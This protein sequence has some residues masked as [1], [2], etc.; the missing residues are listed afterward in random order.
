MKKN[1]RPV[2]L[3]VWLLSLPLLSVCLF[4]LIIFFTLLRWISGTECRNLIEG[5][6]SDALHAASSLEALHWG[7]FALSSRA[8]HAKG[9]AALRT[10]E[11][12][13]VRAHLNPRSIFRGQWLVEEISLGKLSLRLRS[14]PVASEP[15][16]K[17][18][19]PSTLPKWIP[20]LVIV[21]ALRSRNADFFLELSP[22]REIALLGT[23]L[24]VHPKGGEMDLEASKGSLKSPFLPTLDLKSLRATITGSGIAIPEGRFA[25]PR[26]GD[27]RIEGKFPSDQTSSSLSG[28]WENVPFGSLLTALQGKVVG[29][30]DGNATALWENGRCTSVVGSLTARSVM[31]VEVPSLVQFARLTGSDVFRRL[32]VDSFSMQ[33]DHRNEVTHW[34]NVVIESKGRMKVTGD[35]IIDTNKAISGKFRIGLSPAT[36]ELVP[37]IARGIFKADPDG[38]SW[39]SVGIAGS[40]ENPTED[41]TQRL[42]S[43]VVGRALESLGK[44][45]L[46]LMPFAPSGSTN[47]LPVM[48]AVPAVA[49]NA[50]K[51]MGQDAGGAINTLGGFLK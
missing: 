39:V 28:S 22:G 13:E 12:T 47:G 30:H 15:L 18:A 44:G 38:F 27:L 19:K 10:L 51:A 35:A 11:A 26:G 7:W 24:V 1:P 5:K 34:R 36:L 46:D 45:V 25:L 41:L 40:I 42:F 20:S 23:T 9:E 37:V 48:P 21:E 31:L 8:F 6:V 32:P 17:K 4:S 43:L 33:F 2:K 16:S 3:I 14:S 50:V 49:T 29:S